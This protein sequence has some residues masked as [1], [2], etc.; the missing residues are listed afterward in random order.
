MTVNAT[1]ATMRRRMKQSRC[2]V[3]RSPHRSAIDNAL[4]DGISQADVR[5]RWNEVVGRDYFSASGISRHYREHV[6]RPYEWLTLFDA[7]PARHMRT[8]AARDQY[9]AL[10]KIV[11][12]GKAALTAGIIVPTASDMLAALRIKDNAE[13][14]EAR[15]TIKRLLDHA[16]LFQYAMMENLP[17]ETRQAIMHDYWRL[18]DE[19]E[20]ELETLDL[21]KPGVLQKIGERAG[22]SGVDPLEP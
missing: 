15:A 22:L 20:D 3:C 16:A 6:Q 12:L 21:S 18:L 8:G 2:K 13:L 17:V 1:E 14:L 4:R 9:I 10:T 11:D 19:C 5:R 7:L